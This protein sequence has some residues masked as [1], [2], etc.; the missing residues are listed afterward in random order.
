VAWQATAAATID[1]YVK[2]E[3]LIHRDISG[4]KWRKLKYNLEQVSSDNKKGIITFG[5]AFSNHIHATAAA[6]YYYGISTVGIIRG[7]ADP[8]NPTLRQAQA[9]GM[10]LHYVSRSAYRNKEDAEDVQAILAKYPGYLLLPEGGSNQTATQGTR[11]IVTE[12]NTQKDITHMV[13]SAGTGATAAGMITALLPHQHLWVVSALKGDFLKREINQYLSTPSKQWT[14][15]TDY[16]RG[17]YARV[18]NALID[19]IHTYHQ[20]TGIALDPIYNAKSMMALDDLV[21]KGQIPTGSTV[22]YI[23]TGGL[24]GIAACNYM[25]S[26]RGKRGINVE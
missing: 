21:A 23:H 2:R 20:E 12:L 6:G 18:D 15:L 10:R 19:Y 13:V 8:S 17:G 1:L 9:W 25:A 22:A 26:K 24:Q 14:L 11:E 5:G 16:H 4:N 3:E 7:E